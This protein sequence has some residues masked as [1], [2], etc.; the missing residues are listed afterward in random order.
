MRPALR[1]YQVDVIA[2][3]DAEV[4]AG[5]RRVL[6]E[7]HHAPARTYRWIL[8][9]YPGAAVI[10]LTATPCRGDGRGLGGIFDTLV[11][12]PQVAELIALGFLVP[13]KVFAPY[14][15]D[16]AGVR[17]ER[18]DY[19]EKQLAERMDQHHLVGDIT[20]TWL[21]LGKGR[22][23]V[24]FATSVSHSVHI[25][26]QF[27]STGVLAEHI[28]GT[29]PAEDRDAILALLAA[30]KIDVVTNCAVLTEGWDSPSTACI[31][32]AR[33]TRSLGL[34]RQMVGRALR[35]F[36]GKSDAL[37][38]DHAGATFEHGFVE[39]PVAWTLSPDRRA[40]SPAQIARSLGHAPLLTTCPECSG[41]RRQGRPCPCCG[42]RPQP[43]PVA[44]E[45]VDGELGEVSREG[46]VTAPP[47]DREL[48]YRQLLW[49]ALDRDYKPA[50]AA[51]KYEAR[52]GVWPP[53]GPAEPLPP[54]QAT[55]RWV[56]AEHRAFRKSQRAAG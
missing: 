6:D 25:R 52:F 14:V 55:L 10:G 21:R 8:E 29:T 17:V 54:S 9:Q 32:I 37:V 53:R 30:G 36:P 19:V 1:P 28:D 22:P 24:V 13:T 2:R 48:F 4:D 44:V 15:P 11:E 20:S 49:I 35:P 43:K 33:P 41:V 38:L 3:V 40:V 39:E 5:R 34:F 56:R 51:Y 42:W 23:T 26:D 18:G 31:I 46:I 12:G 16:L 50:W 7:A 27:R 47:D 45:M